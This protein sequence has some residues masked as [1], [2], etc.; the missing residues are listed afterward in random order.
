MCWSPDR[1]KNSFM[2]RVLSSVSRATKNIPCPTPLFNAKWN[3]EI[4]RYSCCATILMS[5]ATSSSCVI[6][7]FYCTDKRVLDRSLEPDMGHWTKTL[8]HWHRLGPKIWTSPLCLGSRV[9]RPLMKILLRFEVAKILSFSKSLMEVFYIVLWFSKISSVLTSTKEC[10][11]R[12]SGYALSS[13]PVMLWVCE[14]EI[15]CSFFFRRS[16]SRLVV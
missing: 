9:G 7:P 1:V 12:M 15:C 14:H 4:F 11:H 5:S 16:T 2:N 3:G 8:K 6:K 10:C 13:P